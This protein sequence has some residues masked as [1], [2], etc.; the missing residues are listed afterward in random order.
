M[1]TSK[2]EWETKYSNTIDQEYTV[3]YKSKKE[4]A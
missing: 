3:S 4:G 2:M 1:E